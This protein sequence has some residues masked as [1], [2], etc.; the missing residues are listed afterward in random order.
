M[1]SSVGVYKSPDIAFAKNLLY[2]F[3]IGY[4]VQK[5]L[6]KFAPYI[7]LCTTMYTS[8]AGAS[9]TLDWGG[10]QRWFHTP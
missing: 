6:L 10:K 7:T 3:A 4:E 5:R 2:V 1:L 9:I 8:R